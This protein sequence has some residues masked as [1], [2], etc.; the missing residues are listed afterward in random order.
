MAIDAGHS[1]GRGL[2]TRFRQLENVAECFVDLHGQIAG[3]FD[4]L[5]LV[6]AHWHDVAVINQNVRRHE[7]RIIEQSNCGGHAAGELVFVR[8]GALEQTHRRYCR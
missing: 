6:F 8:G 5:L 3:D 2:D 4:V 1:F 7:H